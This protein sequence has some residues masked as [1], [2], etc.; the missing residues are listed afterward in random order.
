MDGEASGERGL[1]QRIDP[2]SLGRIGSTVDADDVFTA[3]QQGVQ[4][5]LAECL[6]PMDDD[7]HDVSPPRTRRAMQRIGALTHAPV[8]PR[9]PL[10]SFVSELAPGCRV[11]S[12]QATHRAGL[13]HRFADDLGCWHRA[14]HSYAPA[15]ARSAKQE[16]FAQNY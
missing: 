2:P 4:H 16:R 14:L 10:T 8:A 13:S 11:P 7:A 6:L 15:E 12:N 5:A 1:L 3:L 9:S